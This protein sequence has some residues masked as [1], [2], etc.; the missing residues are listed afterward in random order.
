MLNLLAV[1]R[2]QPTNGWD[3]AIYIATIVVV[4]IIVIVAILND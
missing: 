3:A 2:H 4:G 1:T